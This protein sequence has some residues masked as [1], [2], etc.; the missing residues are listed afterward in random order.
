MNDIVAVIQTCLK[1]RYSVYY[2]IGTACNL[3]FHGYT[4]I[5]HLC[6]YFQQLLENQRKLQ[7]KCTKSQH[8][9][10][11]MESFN[12]LENQDSIIAN[13]HNYIK[14]LN[15]DFDDGVLYIDNITK[16]SANLCGIEQ[17]LHIYAT[18]ERDIL[19]RLV[20]IV[21]ALLECNHKDIALTLL[22]CI[23]EHGSMYNQ[24]SYAM[25]VH[26]LAST[27]LK[28]S[29]YSK[30]LPLYDS[31][32]KLVNDL[33]IYD[34]E[35]KCH[36]DLSRAYIAINDTK[37]A[38]LH[39]ESALYV[40][41]KG[42]K[43]YDN[44]KNSDEISRYVL[45]KL[46][47][48]HDNDSNTP[49]IT[50]SSIQDWTVE[51]ENENLAG[52]SQYVFKVLGS[53]DK[54][55]GEHW[56]H[57]E[58]E[59]I[60]KLSVMY[61]VLGLYK[62]ALKYAT[63]H[64][65]VL[66]TRVG[67][68]DANLLLKQKLTKEIT[69]QSSGENHE[70]KVNNSQLKHSSDEVN[71][72][73]ESH[74]LTESTI[75]NDDDKSKDTEGERGDS[76]QILLLEA[77]A[78]L[79]SIYL[80]LQEYKLAIAA[81]EA[82]AVLSRKA[83]KTLM[84][85]TAY[86]SIG[87]AYSKMGNYSLA[88][89]YCEQQLHL[90]MKAA[91]S[92]S[93][94]DALLK[95]GDICQSSGE[96]L[97]AINYYDKTLTLSLRTYSI[98]YEACCKLTAVYY[99]M[100]HYRQAQISAEQALRLAKQMLDY[101]KEMISKYHLSYL[102]CLQNNYEQSI[103]FLYEVVSYFEND[104]SRYEIELLNSYR[105]I[106]EV[107]I[108]LDRVDEAL[109]YAEKY[110]SFRLVEFVKL[111]DQFHGSRRDNYSL[112]LEE[113]LSATQSMSSDSMLLYY[114]VVHGYIYLWLISP[115]RDIIRFHQVKLKGIGYLCNQMQNF[116]NIGRSAVLR[117]K[118]ATSPE[119]SDSKIIPNNAGKSEMPSARSV[120]EDKDL[121]NQNDLQR[122]YYHTENRKLFDY[123]QSHSVRDDPTFL[124]ELYERIQCSSVLSALKT[125]YAKLISPIE[126]DLNLASIDHLII[127]C[128][129]HLAFV[130]YYTLCDACGTS[131]Y[132]KF[133]VS[134][135]SSLLTL[136][137]ANSNAM[138][139]S[140]HNYATSYQKPRVH[141]YPY[142]LSL[143]QFKE[144]DKKETSDNIIQSE[145]ILVAGNPVFKQK[146]A[147]NER[148]WKSNNPLSMS[149]DEVRQIGLRLNTTPLVGSM[150]TKERVLQELTKASVVHLS[151]L[152][153][154]YYN[155]L[156][157]TP[158]PYRLNTDTAEEDSYLVTM[159][160]LKQIKLKAKIIVL[161]SCSQNSYSD[162]NALHQ[163]TYHLPNMLLACGA[164]SV[165]V[166]LWPIP[167]L[168]SDAFWFHFYSHLYKHQ[169]L[170]LA[171]KSALNSIRE[172]NRLVEPVCWG[173][174]VLLGQ[175]MAIDIKQIEH[176][177]LN[178]SIDEQKMRM[179]TLL[180]S[181]QTSSPR[182][183]SFEE[184]NVVPSVKMNELQ[185]LL[186]ELFKCYK[187]PDFIQ[188]VKEMLQLIDRAVAY[189]QDLQQNPDTMQLSTEMA[190]IPACRKLLSLIGF[191]FQSNP[192]QLDNNCVIFPHW[193]YDSLLR[194][195]QLALRSIKGIVKF[196][197]CLFAISKLL[198][199]DDKLHKYL[200]KLLHA[201]N[202]SY[203]DITDSY[204]HNVWQ[205][206]PKSRQLLISLG[207]HQAGTLLIPDRNLNA[208]VRD[209]CQLLLALLAP[210]SNSIKPK[211]NRTKSAPES[212]LNEQ[213]FS[214]RP[215]ALTPEMS[216][217]SSLS[218][219]K[220]PPLNDQSSDRVLMTSTWSP[221]TSFKTSSGTV[222][223]AK[224]M[225]ALN[226]GFSHY[227]IDADEWHQK[228]VGKQG[229]S[230]A[231][232]SNDLSLPAEGVVKVKSGS[233]PSCPRIPI[234][235]KPAM[236]STTILQQRHRGH[237]AY[238]EQLKDVV[239]HKDYTI[240]QMYHMSENEL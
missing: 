146:L 165:L 36:L 10:H 91:D 128:G 157:F 160:D 101:D 8:L 35:I 34:I 89:A 94:M 134:I 176:H 59:V 123:R 177:M 31:C 145:C 100:K 83:N 105:Y 182:D 140:M 50:S 162:K 186:A 130:P 18:I 213:K 143:Q 169:R 127:V 117:K 96:L 53:N 9:C 45:S 68:H 51:F 234:N 139:H 215:T 3:L 231:A 119:N 93:Q 44:K 14:L 163:L 237:Q 183:K 175:D 99:T 137:I 109:M 129:N 178:K 38:I 218:S 80:L 230:S 13:F 171:L 201:T 60:G 92:S 113:I 58:E 211:R 19:W 192:N 124:H 4:A 84:L 114:S 151:T 112:S 21:S 187:M 2:C 97:K 226:T 180:T 75:K 156:A 132:Q 20:V 133:K 108:K 196:P 26:M 62:E 90:S 233:S 55:T 200:I 135:F 217:A 67:N 40:G 47:A 189:V 198:P 142:D 120:L 41:K 207:Y 153:C 141:V 88:L 190:E 85:G 42:S 28:K 184:I 219:F 158:N 214:S 48:S 73:C 12:L 71:Q 76:L 17:K 116:S 168:A 222:K 131:L 25:A 210:E 30:A 232:A 5:I 111:R 173:S 126:N 235:Y 22:D 49:S 86:G 72:K 74:D 225:D 103:V 240:D 199:L 195:C 150:A 161:S 223:L 52:S 191:N 208:Q 61:K 209:C 152:G 57:C 29:D 64:I 148:V 121:F 46:N 238:N 24:Y 166:P 77:H 205:V 227:A 70:K 37:M 170:S 110:N 164:C 136:Q 188:I 185:K 181:K 81:Y 65:K 78:N 212:M 1:Q 39:Y 202:S 167:D 204:V 33:S 224:R 229:I 107:L 125:L 155:C 220:L 154:L 216:D 11:I 115:T 43:N 193:D 95:L 197:S 228:Q 149:L 203:I 194:P 7:E 179:E 56:L 69:I 122:L 98:Q 32:L 66:N 118:R 87:V 15:D 102:H 63:S 104:L 6:R 54:L 82:L 174:Y 23:V 144:G 206:N 27:H 106:Q 236:T 159:D 172:D 221:R 239:D 147:S 138:K 79:G 16:L